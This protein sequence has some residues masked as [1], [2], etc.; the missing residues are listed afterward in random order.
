MCRLYAFRSNA[1]SRVECDLVHAQN[2]LMAQS[3]RDLS[4]R[5][6]VNGWGVATYDGAH[7]HVERQAW[8]AYHGEHFR[9]SVTGQYARLFLAHVRRATVGAP[10]LDNTHP[11][12]WGRWSFIHN[13]TVHEFARV[14]DR[15]REVMLPH[16]REAIRGTTDSEHLFHMMMSYLERGS[17]DPMA[18]LRATF[19]DLLAW[20]CG[21]DPD[22][23]NGLNVVLTDGNHL[24][25]TRWGR[26]LY[27]L[28]RDALHVCDI[29][30]QTHAR[31][32]PDVGY[33]A[34]VI[35]SEPLTGEP[36]REMPDRTLWQVTPDVELRCEP[37]A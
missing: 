11:F 20:C 16:H 8:A 18:A 12:V 7:I 25:G 29:C 36:W 31:L 27:Q 3:R 6:H 26:T 14:R 9:R 2:A 15:M 23:P 32:E 22:T 21:G 28:E 24:V 13:G 30:A 17:G 19:E 35:A 5:E 34:V 1:Q 4:G 33:R 37:W 10:S